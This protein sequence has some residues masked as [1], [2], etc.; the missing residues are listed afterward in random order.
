M[1]T[2]PEADILAVRRRIKD[3]HASHPF[4]DDDDIDSAIQLAVTGDYSR[5]RPREVVVDE[6]GTGTP[7]ICLSD[8]EEWEDN[9]S[10]VVSVEYPALDI[11]SDTGPPQYLDPVNEWREYDNASKRYLHLRTTTP[12]VTDTLRIILTK[13]HSLSKGVAATE[14][15]PVSITIAD[16]AV[17]TRSDH[18]LEDGD[19][20]RL[21]TTG[22]LPT[23][24]TAGTTYYVVNSTNDTLQLAATEDG[25]PIETTG[26]Q[27]G[28]HSM[29]VLSG[30][31]E[32]DRAADTIYTHDKNAVLDLAASI[33]ALMAGGRAA[34]SSDP[35]LRNTGVKTDLTYDQWLRISDEW[36]GRYMRHM[37]RNPDG[38][39]MAER[40]EFVAEI[41]DWDPLPASQT[42]SWLTHE[43]RRT[44]QQ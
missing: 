29:T 43:R 30:E 31:G 9:F 10:R 5:H 23:G 32:E 2:S 26:T 22:A 8:L 12:A 3:T 28:V 38:S 15:T 21:S 41:T 35:G 6:S 13:T 19:T 1:T 7:F 25:D 37:N 27:S 24:L 16:P 34:H 14:F 40:E 42:G 11:T 44:Y 39:A 20:V 4:L 36:R 18:F 17:L 33:A